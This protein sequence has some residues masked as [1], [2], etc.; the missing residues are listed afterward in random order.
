MSLART[1]AN[2]RPSGEISGFFSSTGVLVIRV[3]VEEDKSRRKMS[4]CKIYTAWRPA[5]SKPSGQGRLDFTFADES[6]D[7]REATA[8]LIS[9]IGWRFSVAGS[10]L[11]NV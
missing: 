8:L 7:C 11:S 5:L 10:Y 6:S 9:R 3:N 4:P 2:L 1:K